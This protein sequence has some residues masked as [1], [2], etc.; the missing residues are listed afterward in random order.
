[1]LVDDY[2]TTCP[3]PSKPLPPGPSSLTGP[4]SLSSSNSRQE[5]RVTHSNSFSGSPF[6]RISGSRNSGVRGSCEHNSYAKPNPDPRWSTVNVPFFSGN[7]LSG[8]RRLCCYVSHATLNPEPRNSDC[9]SASHVFHL[10]PLWAH[11]ATSLFGIS[12][13]A[14]PSCKFPWCRKPRNAE[15]RYPGSA[16]TR[17]SVDRRFPLLREIATRDFTGHK[18]LVSQNPERRNP[19]TLD[20][21]H[22]SSYDRRLWSNREIAL[23][24][25][26]EYKPL[27]L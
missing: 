24:D 9:T 26:A 17:P 10:L 14:N 15:P 13:I 4:K 3:S 7:F 18:T 5:S 20:S 23:R 27:A 16:A 12:R 11:D 2:L 6:F 1:M 8:N 19:E 22:L 25:F 21:C